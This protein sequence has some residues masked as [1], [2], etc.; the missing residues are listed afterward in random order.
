MILIQSDAYPGIEFHFLIAR[1]VAWELPRLK[2]DFNSPF[3]GIPLSVSQVGIEFIQ[4]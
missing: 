1:L 2:T 4:K 3:K